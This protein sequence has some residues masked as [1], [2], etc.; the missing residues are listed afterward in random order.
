MSGEMHQVSDLDRDILHLLAKGWHTT[1]QAKSEGIL[2]GEEIATRV[3]V[4][5]ETVRG[6]LVFL[7]TMG[8]VVN[9]QNFGGDP[10]LTLKGIDVGEGAGTQLEP[11]YHV[12]EHGMRMTLSEAITDDLTTEQ[13]S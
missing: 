4:D 1:E 7:E 2:S 11:R 9:E 6:R 12:S 3:G 10:T 8:Y 5:L 13:D